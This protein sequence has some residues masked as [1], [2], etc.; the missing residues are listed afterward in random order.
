MVAGYF[1]AVMGTKKAPVTGYTVNETM[2]DAMA[3]SIGRGYPDIT[4][5]GASY[6][7]LFKIIS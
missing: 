7:V 5:A 1:N 2:G 3:G 6:Q 4:L